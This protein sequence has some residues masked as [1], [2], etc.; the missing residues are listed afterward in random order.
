MTRKRVLFTAR[1]VGH[2][3]WWVFVV[4]ALFASGIT[5]WMTEYVA[6]DASFVGRSYGWTIYTPTTVAGYVDLMRSSG[7]EWWQDP[8]VYALAAFVAVVIA[9]IVDALAARRLIA[10]IITV[11]APFVALGL[12]V[13]ATPGAVDEVYPHGTVSLVLILIGVAIREVWMRAI[14]PGVRDEPRG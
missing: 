11:A 4:A 7:P 9:A 3:M 5:W 12:F 1:T 2:V 13:L 10:G 8:A 14:A 6:V